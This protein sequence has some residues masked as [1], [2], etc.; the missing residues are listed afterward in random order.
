MERHPLD[1]IA[2]VTGLVTLIGG[3]IALLHQQGAFHLGVGPV[4]LL[5]CGLLGAGGVALVVLTSR[6]PGPAPAAAPADPAAA[7]S[8]RPAP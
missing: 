1:P 2:L 6:P 8:P 4:V 3:V 7:E 5:A